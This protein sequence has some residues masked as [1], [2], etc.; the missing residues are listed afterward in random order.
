MQVIFR[1]RF[2]VVLGSTRT[3]PYP[4][5]NPINKSRLPGRAEAADSSPH[6]GK[7]RVWVACEKSSDFGVSKTKSPKIY[8]KFLYAFFR[9]HVGTIFI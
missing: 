9:S 1:R 4:S 3:H 8:V 5:T 2:P 7:I 6:C